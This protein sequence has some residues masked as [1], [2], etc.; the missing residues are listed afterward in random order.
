MRLSV[1]PIFNWKL[2][3]CWAPNANEIYTKNMKFTW[4]TFAFGAQ[5]NLYSADSRWGF[6]LGNAQNLRH[7][8][9]EIPT[10]WYFLRN[11]NVLSF[12]LGDAKVP[13]KNGFAS[14]W[15]IGFRKFTSKLV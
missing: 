13:N 3:L 6:A 12:V 11:A 10:C 9:Q 4:P 8:M 2:G 14:Q 15:N 1:K 7:P 5:R